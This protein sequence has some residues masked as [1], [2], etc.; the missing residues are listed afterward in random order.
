MRPDTTCSSKLRRRSTR[1]KRP[2]CLGN[3]GILF[4]LA[5]ASGCSSEATVDMSGV[6]AFCAKPTGKPRAVPLSELVLSPS[7]YEGAHVQTEGYF[8]SYF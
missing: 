1:R 7:A 8:Y 3:W 6:H 2:G 4:V 5:C